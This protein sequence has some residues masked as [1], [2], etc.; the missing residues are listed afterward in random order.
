MHNI[1]TVALDTQSRIIVAE[2]ELDT[3]VDRY[4]GWA[5]TFT[6]GTAGSQKYAYLALDAAL[7]GKRLP[8]P[9]GMPAC[10]STPFD[11]MLSPIINK[12]LYIKRQTERIR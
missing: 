1:D 11:R 8:A 5:D 2:N 9:D 6:A 3:L 12:V 4:N 7:D 10:E